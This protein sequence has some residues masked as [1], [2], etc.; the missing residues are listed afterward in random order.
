MIKIKTKELKDVLSKLNLA[1]EKSAFNP[2]SGWVQIKIDSSGSIVIKVANFDY[3]VETSFKTENVSGENLFATVEAE[4]FVPL[5]SKISSEYIELYKEDKALILKTKN[6]LYTFPMQINLATGEISDVDAIEFNVDDYSTCELSEGEVTSIATVNAKGIGENSACKKII[7]QFIYVDNLGAETFT[8]NIYVNGFKAHDVE[9]KFLLNKT[10][11]KILSIFSGIT[12]I[13][14]DVEN[15]KNDEEK[16]KVRFSGKNNDIEISVVF[17]TQAFNIVKQY[18]SAKL[19]EIANKTIKTH[20]IV[21]REELNK[22]LARLMVFDKKFGANVW[23]Y[24]KIEWGE[25]EFKLVSVK[26]KN[27]EVIPYIRSKNTYKHESVIR[28]ADLVEQLKAFTSKE[29][30]MSYGEAPVIVINADE[31]RQLIP[32]I[33]K[34]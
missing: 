8:D 11:A 9:F 34:K 18:P 6:N 15:S 3:Y 24:S 1:I 29:I 19:R 12:N 25:N 10:Q 22:A 20:A 31:L 26:S 5:V 27:Y 33:I 4:T 16:R 32:E 21:D 13:V 28:F 14:V 7:Q 30:D 23:D 17:I 2:Q